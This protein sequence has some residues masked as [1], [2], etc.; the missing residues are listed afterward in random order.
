[1]RRGAEL[2]RFLRVV[3]VECSFGKGQ[4]LGAETNAVRQPVTS[5]GDL[6]EPCV[7]VGGYPDMAAALGTLGGRGERSLG[8]IKAPVAIEQIAEPVF[9]DGRVP[10]VAD[11][12]I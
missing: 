8:L 5:I 12:G 10:D 2:E 6:C 1:M 3:I 4:R 7:M 11:L 9:G